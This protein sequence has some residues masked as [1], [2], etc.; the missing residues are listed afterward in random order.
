MPEDGYLSDAMYTSRFFGFALPLPLDP[1]GHLVKLPLMPPRQHALLALA[2]EEGNRSGSISIDAIEPHEGLDGPQAE[3]WRV[4]ELDRLQGRLGEDGKP[5]PGQAATVTAPTLTVKPAPPAELWRPASFRSTLHRK[6]DTYTATYWTRIHD[7]R[8]GVLVRTNDPEFLR[9]SKQAMHEVRFYCP[10]DDGMLV[11]AKG[12]V[13]KPEGEGYEGPTV[14]TWHADA[15]L[16]AKPGLEIAPGAVSDG[17]YRNP[18]LGLESPIPSGWEVLP[19]DNTG[20]PP[21]DL[22]GLREFQFFQ[23][24]SRTLLR[25]RRPGTGSM[26]VLRALDAECLGLQM[27]AAATDTR[28]AEELQASLEALSDMG[29]FS[30]NQIVSNAG[31]LF[32]ALHGT[33]AAPDESAGLSQ[34]LS[35]TVFITKGDK[36]LLAWSVAAP[37][38][39]ELHADSLS[40]IVL[41]STKGIALQP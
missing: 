11:S 15:A 25:L 41:D 28:A 10:D 21:A 39:K 27:P 4:R 29:Q 32:L 18:E 23:A 13:V 40:G 5:L 1:Q 33:I 12:E 37:T 6:G 30:G 19:A 38:L 9:K 34:R 14:P 36:L 24:C 8:I 35:Q 17:M 20:N 16:L 31:R 2:F 3:D 7:Y 26:I 22:T